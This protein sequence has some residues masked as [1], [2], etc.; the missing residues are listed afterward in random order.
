MFAGF[1][2]VFLVET[3]YK[4]LK[5]NTH[6]MIVE[7]GQPYAAEIVEYLEWAE[8]YSWRYEFFYN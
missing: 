2:V 4:L 5:Y 7:G 1:F 3:P 8:I 6:R